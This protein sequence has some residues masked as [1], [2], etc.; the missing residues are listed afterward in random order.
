MEEAIQRAVAHFH[1][2]GNLNGNITNSRKLQFLGRH[3]GSRKK[4]MDGVLLKKERQNKKDELIYIFFVTKEA[5]YPKQSSKPMSIHPF[6]V[7]RS[8]QHPFV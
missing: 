1:R 4:K 5:E 8:L 3:L 7:P 2:L 6:E